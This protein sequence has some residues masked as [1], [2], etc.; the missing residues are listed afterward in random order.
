M[1]IRTTAGRRAAALLLFATAT[2]AAQCVE[3]DPL[4]L[5]DPGGLLGFTFNCLAADLDADG[6]PDLVAPSTAGTFIYRNDGLPA[7]SFT[8]QPLPSGAAGA[9]APADLDNDGDLD[10]VCI[11]PQTGAVFWMEQTSASPL[12]FTRRNI[13]EHDSGARDV[14]AAD[15]NADGAIDFLT[16]AGDDGQ[17]HVYLSDGASPPSF[18]I[19]SLPFNDFGV[20]VWT[21]DIDLDGDIDILSVASE[22]SLVWYANNGAPMPLF[23]PRVIPTIPG[24]SAAALAD[25]DLDGD[26]DIVVA[27]STGPVS[28]AAWL[29]N[30]GG[31][32]PSFTTRVFSN[33]LSDA[34]AIRIADLDRDGRPDIIIASRADDQV[35][36]YRNELVGGGPRFVRRIISVSGGSGAP[37]AIDEP[38][39]LAVLDAQGDGAPDIYALSN[40]RIAVLFENGPPPPAQFAPMSP[41]Q[42]AL[43]VA[44]SS[45]L[46][47][48]SAGCEIEYEVT[49]S[50]SP[51]LEPPLLQQTVGSTVL[52]L[53]EGL[54]EQESTYHWS[55]VA[56]NRRGQSVITPS[57]ATFTTIF[58][59][60]LNADGMLNMSDLNIL[61]TFF[62]LAGP[63]LTADLNGDGVVGFA[64]LN[65]LLSAIRNFQT[66]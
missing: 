3:F 48:T 59:A 43:A 21:G 2:G 28:S 8:P 65:I 66:R 12:E 15:L 40:R 37:A 20:S 39:G 34:R 60:D 42:G 63:G 46:R 61:L 35:S 32:P 53:P 4:P 6:H 56:H 33:A 57:P 58:A 38:V 49:L 45:P 25:L 41:Q 5:D 51:T 23:Q 10:L 55:V 18:Q 44:L 30:T 54:L 16:F 9:A 64:D 50:A 13:A 17:L 19:R 7:P 31:S 47:W 24:L 52:P 62:G 22:S 1:G 11:L 27:T 26:L 36:W 29:E 14:H